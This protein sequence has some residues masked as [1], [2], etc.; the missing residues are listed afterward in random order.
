MNEE[1]K[2]VLI[3]DRKKPG[4]FYNW[5]SR[6][7]IIPKKNYALKAGEH[8][9]SAGYPLMSFDTYA[10]GWKEI[11]AL[12]Y[13]TPEA[14]NPIFWPSK[15]TSCVHTKLFYLHKSQYPMSFCGFLCHKHFRTV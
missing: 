15:S 13:K 1:R 12:D 5:L 3:Y 6:D 11:I 8:V 4:S 2:A 7:P 14:H 9:A 10:A